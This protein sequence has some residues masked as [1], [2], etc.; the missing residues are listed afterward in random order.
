MPHLS[1]KRFFEIL[2]G[3]LSWGTIVLMVFS[4]WLIPTAAAIFIIAFDTYWFLKTVYLS[5]HLRGAFGRMRKNMNT[6]WLEHLV[7]TQ[8]SRWESVTHLIILPMYQEPYEVVKE[9][10]V[11]LIRMNYPKKKC[12]VVLAAEAHAPESYAIAKKIEQEF[13]R[14]FFRFLTITHPFGLPGEIPGKGSN[15]SWAA[16]AAKKEIIDPLRIPYENIL[17]SVFDADTQIAPDYFGILTHHFLTVSNPQRSSFQP[18]PLFTNNIFSAPTLARVIA[19]SSTF[20]HM[21]QQSRSEQLTTFS[22]HS[23]PFQALVEVGFWNKDIVSE[24]SQIFWQCYLHYHGDW[25]V[26]PLYYPVSMDANVASTFWH[27]M[28]NL[29]KQQRRWAW[30]VENIPYAFSGFWNN[31]LIPLK[32]K[33]YWMFKKIDASWSWATNSLLIFA[34]GWLPVLLGGSEFNVSV[35]SYNLP[36]LTRLIMIGAMIG[37][38][39]SAVLSMM[40]LPPKPRWFKWHHSLLYIIQWLLMPITLIVFGCIPALD[41]QTRL[42]LGG[43]W[44]LGF[45]STPKFRNSAS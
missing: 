3:F 35:L 22:S 2:P 20:W 40:L 18:I 17:V 5:M 36:R 33:G 21:M 26:V 12:I 8:K 27:T 11:S 29:Y 41:A 31:S 7:H 1:Q 24:D 28:K 44:R 34:L 13:G 38:V 15:E 6:N 14:E 39:S 32:E 16:N 19:F 37:I 45:W 10:I 25:R 23:M 4:S 30:G 42:A 9:S 43:A